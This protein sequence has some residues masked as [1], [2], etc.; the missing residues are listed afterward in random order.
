MVCTMQLDH[1][2]LIES[3]PLV[4][5]SLAAQLAQHHAFDFLCVTSTNLN[6]I[7]LGIGIQESEIRNRESGIGN[8]ESE[9]RNRE[10][11]IGNREL[12]TG[13]EDWA[14]LLIFVVA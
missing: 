11:G 13:I 7:D 1:I 6:R 10:S 3:N 8:Q 5:L 12:G 4:F 2:L 9:I 14:C